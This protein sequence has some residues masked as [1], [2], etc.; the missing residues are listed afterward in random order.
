VQLRQRLQRLIT[1][2]RQPALVETY[3]P[4]REFTVGLLGNPLQ[5]GEVPL[6]DKYDRRG[7]HLFPV[8]EID[9]SPVADSEQG[10][11]TNRIKS[12]MPLAINYLC[13][14]AI[15]RR[16]ELELKRLSVEAFLT[17][18][19]LDVSRVDFR[20]DAQGR[21]HILEINTLPGMN[22]DISDLCIMARAEGMQYS[23]LVNDI[24]YLAARRYRLAGQA[25]CTVAAQHQAAMA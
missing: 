19:G 16:L 25:G 3:L 24:L 11:Y 13:P 15:E 8:L 6:S 10:I 2:Y 22:P 1:T 14:A 23:D 12:D 9:T 17:I 7:F 4:G 18:G 21:P 20:L 5:P